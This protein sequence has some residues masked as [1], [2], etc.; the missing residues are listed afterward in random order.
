M[1][2]FIKTILTVVAISNLITNQT[3]GRRLIGFIFKPYDGIN[4]ISNWS[5]IR[6]FAWDVLTCQC[7]LSVYV[8]LIFTLLIGGWGI[9]FIQIPLISMLVSWI[10]EKK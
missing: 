8:G 6:R 9:D 4:T 5:G 7:C 10:I 2:E 1:I 3:I